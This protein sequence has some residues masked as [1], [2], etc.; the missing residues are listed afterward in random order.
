RIG[1]FAEG[2]KI[3]C[4]TPWTLAIAALIIAIIVKLLKKESIGDLCV[5]L[6]I[7]LVAMIVIAIQGENLPSY[8]TLVRALYIVPL[9]SL[10]SLLDGP[11]G[12]KV[13]ERE[14]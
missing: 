2:F 11:L 8:A 10:L 7:T 12:L 1:S 9:A 5:W 3:V 6:G 13:E 4:G 14:V